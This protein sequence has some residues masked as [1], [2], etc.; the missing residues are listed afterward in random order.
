MLID[1]LCS[2]Q[3]VSLY[4]FT[5]ILCKDITIP[6]NTKTLN[7]LKEINIMRYNKINFL[8]LLHLQTPSLPKDIQLGSHHDSWTIDTSVNHLKPAT[9]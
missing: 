2:E 9:E 6:P 3:Q 7:R 5:F 1:C 4:Y 8:V